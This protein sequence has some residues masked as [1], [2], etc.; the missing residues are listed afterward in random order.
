MM[1]EFDDKWTP[2][3]NAQ[4]FNNTFQCNSIYI[5]KNVMRNISHVMLLSCDSTYIAGFH[6]QH[7]LINGI[8]LN[9]ITHSH[10]MRPQVPA[11]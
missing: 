4:H 7:M 8:L 11:K 5:T 1:Y 3:H 6:T 2:Q 10:Y 9:S